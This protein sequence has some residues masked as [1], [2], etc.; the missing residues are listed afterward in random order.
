M[1]RYFRSKVGPWYYLVI[2]FTAGIMLGSAALPWVYDRQSAMLATMVQLPLAVMT[3][4]FELWLL[5]S[6]GYTLESTRLL[7]RSGP[8]S[9]T[10]PL[11]EIQSI[12]PTR[13]PLS[14]PALSLDRLL[15]RHGKKGQIMISPADKQ[16]FLAA[17]EAARLRLA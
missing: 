14:S 11:A 15:I 3:I 12:T 13:N 6:T 9:W 10:V 5:F 1:P 7:I 2:L 8:F 17:V 16:G 4:G